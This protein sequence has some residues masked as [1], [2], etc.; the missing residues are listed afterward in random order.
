MTAP[1]PARRTFLGM[2]VSAALA[3]VALPACA[4]LPAPSPR[5]AA[6]EIVDRTH[7]ATLPVYAKDGRRYVVGALGHEY[8]IRIRNTTGVRIL[9]VT[10]VDGV[11]VVTGE[12]AAPDQSG[13]VIEPWGS[14]EIA[15]WRKSLQRTAAFFFT[16]LGNSYAARTGRPFDVGVIGVAVF[17]ERPQPTVSQLAESKRESRARESAADTAGATAE[18]PAAA[19]A[20]APKLGTGHGRTETSYA[21]RVAFER[22]TTEPAEIVAIQYDRYENLVAQGV[23]PAHPP[24]ARTP[25]P[26]PGGGFVPDPR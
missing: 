14:V 4:H 2:A 23:I 20:P 15:G 3:A 22:A 26:F 6:V 17:A 12:T 5:L 24:I 25:R 10:S 19:Q 11:N 18:R 21:R 13:Y 7:A 1:V 8:A 16:D 9:A